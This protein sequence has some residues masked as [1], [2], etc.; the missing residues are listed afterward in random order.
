[1]VKTKCKRPKLKFH[2]IWS[3]EVL[4]TRRNKVNKEE[5]KTRRRGGRRKEK[6]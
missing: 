6:Y 3:Q 4:E 2:H 5:I 1:L